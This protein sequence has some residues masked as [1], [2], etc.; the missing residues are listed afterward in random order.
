MQEFLNW[1]RAWSNGFY[2]VIN[3]ITVTQYIVKPLTFM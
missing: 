3:F 1:G 2:L